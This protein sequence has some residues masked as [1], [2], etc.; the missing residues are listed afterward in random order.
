MAVH[1]RGEVSF[2]R[3]L[4]IAVLALFLINTLPYGKVNS[5]IRTELEADETQQQHSSD[6]P[7][8]WA[9]NQAIT[10]G[11]Q[12]AGVLV[13]KPAETAIT[14]RPVLELGKCIRGIV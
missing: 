3:F 4:T 6:N 8:E 13:S 2:Q 14:T 7:D 12:R 5:S 10:I 1:H 11:Y 9:F